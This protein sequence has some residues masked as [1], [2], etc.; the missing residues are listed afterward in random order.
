MGWFASFLAKPLGKVVASVVPN[1]VG[2][3][4]QSRENTRARQAQQQANSTQLQT[5]VADAKAAGF[6]PLTALRATGGQGYNI[7]HGGM[8]NAQWVSDAIGAGLRAIDPM[9][10]ER[11]ALEQRLLY[12]QVTAAERAVN[13]QKVQ[14]AL[15]SGPRFDGRPLPRPRLND[16]Q[17]RVFHPEGHPIMVPRAVADSIGVV[18]NGY[19]NAGQ[20]AELLGE[21]GGEAVAAGAFVSG[22]LNDATGLR[23]ETPIT[24]LN[25]WNSV[26]TLPRITFE[27]QPENY[28]NIS[29]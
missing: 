2:G 15:A 14:P 29:P 1:V 24:E 16:E 17:I 23:T 19:I 5:L 27:Y 9:Q 8:S 26:F 12:A 11:D 7:T 3:L 20:M 22:S 10:R 4:I 21:L 25:T 13:A 18:P 28:E 6:N